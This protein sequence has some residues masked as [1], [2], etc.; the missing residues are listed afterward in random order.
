MESEKNGILERQE[1]ESCEKLLEQLQEQL[2]SSNASIRRRAAFSL[3]WMQ[4]DGLDILRETVLGEHSASTKNAAAYGLRK[5]RGRMKKPALEVF[6]QGLES[7]DSSTREVCEH[8]L[9]S[10]QTGGKKPPKKKSASKRRIQDIP[11]KR[12]PNRKVPFQEINW[13]R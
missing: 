6:D 9:E 11:G 1:G 12:N 4:E 8:A 7:D 2:R 5:M 3:S 10:L 13:N